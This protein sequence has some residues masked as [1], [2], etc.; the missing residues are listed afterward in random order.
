MKTQLLISIK[1]I[2]FFTVLTGII[3]PLLITGTSQLIFH[4]KA[5]GSFINKD[6]LR[7]G[8]SLIAQMFTDDRY[9]WPRPSAIGYNPLPSGGSNLSATS[10]ILKESV[11]NQR[12]DFIIK[13]RLPVGTIVPAEMIFASGSGLD[14]HISI[15]SA[16]LQSGR[17][18]GARGISQQ[19]VL[20]LIEKFKDNR[21][22]GIL[23]EPRINVLL[24]NMELDSQN[25]N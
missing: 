24:L 23:G 15:E 18:A 16:R 19:K 25:L 8:S 7:V 14:P 6:N 9:F 10:K 4:D 17:V 5:N 13:N 11:E 22:F 1:I 2:L 3:Y 21:Q 20:E 12:F